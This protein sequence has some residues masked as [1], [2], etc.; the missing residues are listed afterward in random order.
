MTSDLISIDDRD[1][2]NHSLISSVTFLDLVNAG[3]ILDNARV[4]IL[5]TD[6]LNR[7]RISVWGQRNT[8]FILGIVK[9]CDGQAWDIDTLPST[10]TTLSPPVEILE[11]PQIFQHSAKPWELW[12]KSANLEHRN[13]SL[14]QGYHRSKSQRIRESFLPEVLSRSNSYR[15]RG[16]LARSRELQH[17][18]LNELLL[19][20]IRNLNLYGFRNESERHYNVTT[21]FPNLVFSKSRVSRNRTSSNSEKL[22]ANKKTDSHTHI[23]KG[24]KYSKV[25][26]PEMKYYPQYTD[27]VT[28]AIDRKSKMKQLPTWFK[29][30]G[31]ERSYQS[32]IC[33]NSKHFLQPRP[34]NISS[35]SI[36]RSMRD[37]IIYKPTGFYDIVKAS[38]HISDF[39]FPHKV[40]TSSRMGPALESVIFKN[41]TLPLNY[42]QL[43][44][45]ENTHF[46]QTFDI[47]SSQTTPFL[48]TRD[49]VQPPITISE[50]I[51]SEINSKK[52]KLQDSSYFWSSSFKVLD[53][54]KKSSSVKSDMLK[55]TSTKRPTLV[56][57][58]ASNIHEISLWGSETI[59]L[60]K[61]SSSG[62]TLTP[63]IEVESIDKSTLHPS[64]TLKKIEEIGRKQTHLDQVRLYKS[65]RNKDI[66]SGSLQVH[67][68]HV[69]LLSLMPLINDKSR[70]IQSPA[71]G[72]LVNVPLRFSNDVKP[73]VTAKDVSHLQN[74]TSLAFESSIFVNRDLLSRITTSRRTVSSSD[75]PQ[76]FLK[77]EAFQY[78]RDEYTQIYVDPSNRPE[79]DPPTDFL[80]SEPFYFTHDKHLV[81]SLPNAPPLQT[82][83]DFVHGFLESEPFYYIPDNQLFQGTKTTSYHLPR[84]S[85]QLSQGTPLTPSYV[86]V[87]SSLPSKKDPPNGFLE[88]EPFHF[89][90]T[91]LFVTSARPSGSFLETMQYATEPLPATLLSTG[92]TQFTFNPAVSIA[93]PEYTK[94]AMSEW[95]A[96]EL[97][98]ISASPT[99]ND[100]NPS[101]ADQSIALSSSIQIAVMS[102]SA[103][104]SQGEG[105]AKDQG[106]GMMERDTFWPIVAALVVGIPSVIVFG[107][108][109]TVFHRRRT[110][111]PQKL[112]NMQTLRSAHIDT[113]DSD[114]GN[115]IEV[116]SPARGAIS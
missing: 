92:P 31:P 71:W 12:R 65:T 74:Q 30:F 55:P 114:M 100:I 7:Y 49:L 10:A 6:H 11:N 48:F 9:V 79:K 80:L 83:A 36:K 96:S 85:S 5:A 76:G 27:G 52:V 41:Q 46:M 21:F 109:I 35:L 57:K 67:Q 40:D 26:G 108:A 59:P 50:P 91:E 13:D 8:R 81:T 1:R 112:F 97:P 110:P 14:L 61:Q 28:P 39:L 45:S 113:S 32:I 87:A 16:G 23:D 66:L 38:I 82:G 18:R 44:T 101:S 19:D 37:D 99:E 43:V 64:L 60:Y 115:N 29:T 102:S 17:T 53:A 107:I 69:Q 88:S 104:A 62:G 3:Q 75:L 54:G 63:R 20:E 25:V 98:S 51:K 68:N 4:V 86:S 95:S 22:A 70:N 89:E 56:K 33:N 47:I 34:A 103:N 94:T 116:P 15:F 78:V 72:S 2:Y 105:Y 111:D 77:S 42:T 84:D 24:F 106:Q 90:A 93:G 73:S 58:D